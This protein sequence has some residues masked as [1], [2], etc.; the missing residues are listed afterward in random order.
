MSRLR[1]WIRRLRGQP[2]ARPAPPWQRRAWGIG[3]YR[4]ASPLDLAP[5][6][7]LNPVL[8]PAAVSDA[9][10]DL[11]AD[12]FMLPTPAGWCLFFEVLDWE[13]NRGR[14]WLATSPDGLRWEYRQI[15]LAEAFHLSYPHVFEWQGEHYM[16]PESYQAEAV[17]LYRAVEFP[18]RWA[19]A[20]TLLSGGVFLDSS[21]FRH[22]GRWWLFT[23]T[24]RAG[25]DLWLYSAEDLHGPWRAHPLSPIVRADAR[26]ARPAG[27]VIHHA[28]RL[29]RLAQEC[30]PVYGTQVRA[31][32]ITQLTPE[33]YAEQPAQPQAVLAGSG[34]GWNRDGMHHLDA[35]ALEDGSWL[36][37]VDGWAQ[38]PAD[39]EAPRH[40]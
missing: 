30:A 18:T 9:P 39:A 5:A 3:I 25:D 19:F 10:A 37:C 1:Q 23:T 22:A 17:R 8:T 7:G 35:H 38:G 34:S 36:A 29:L 28:G 27:R 24:R 33:L 15:V 20:Q 13:S 2:P 40:D 6:G 14:I 21:P 12:P 4:G 32:E 11:V 26:I 31:F 16:I